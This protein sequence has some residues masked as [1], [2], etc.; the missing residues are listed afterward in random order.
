MKTPQY[1]VHSA[2]SSE[3]VGRAGSLEDLLKKLYD[4]K[5][6][7][8]LLNIIGLNKKEPW[9]FY[10]KNDVHSDDY[11]AESIPLTT[12]QKLAKELGI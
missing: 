6:E 10:K 3:I 1:F 9:C 11:D 5:D 7:Y 2:C 4:P 8:S 12:I